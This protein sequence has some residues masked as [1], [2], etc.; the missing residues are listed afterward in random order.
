M[1]ISVAAL[2]LRRF[3]N[4]P[5]VSGGTCGYA[6]RS[7]RR[8]RTRQRTHATENAFQ[9]HLCHD[10]H[11]SQPHALAFGISLVSCVTRQEEVSP[12]VAWSQLR[13]G[14][15]RF[16]TVPFENM[17]CGVLFFFCW[18][19]SPACVWLLLMR[20]MREPDARFSGTAVEALV[21][22]RSAIAYYCCIES[23]NL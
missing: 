15:E 7:R 14:A 23:A 11:T 18:L 21:Q 19:F 2:S 6:T 5:P 10:W 13:G 1:I 22:S 3:F 9:R 4:G 16:F 12:A 8:A 17:F 20:D